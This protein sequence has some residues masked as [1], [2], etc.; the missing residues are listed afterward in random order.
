MLLET[1]PRGCRGRLGRPG[2]QPPS[3]P[4][5]RA[6]EQPRTF[7]GS[8]GFPASQSSP[9]GSEHRR[10]RAN[11]VRISGELAENATP[12]PAGPESSGIQLET[13]MEKAALANLTHTTV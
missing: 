5:P 13:T 1:S 7:P 8:E 12:H 11:R 3:P 6:W 2:P 4:G 9:E 10:L